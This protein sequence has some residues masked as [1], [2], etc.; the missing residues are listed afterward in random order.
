M[1]IKLL[2]TVYWA[3][4]LRTGAG[5]SNRGQYN[6]TRHLGARHRQLLLRVRGHLSL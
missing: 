1:T 5:Q 3:P 4:R 2:N 6:I